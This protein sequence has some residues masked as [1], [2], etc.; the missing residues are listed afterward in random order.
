[1]HSKYRVVCMHWKQIALLVMF[2]VVGVNLLGRSYIPPLE[3][4]QEM[5]M[6]F[7]VRNPTKYDLE[8]LNVKVHI[9]D[10]GLTLFSNEFHLNDETHKLVR[11]SWIAPSRLGKGSYL[12]RISVGNDH[13][14]DINHVSLTAN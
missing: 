10:L 3:A 14:K 2:G 1:M 13:L 11:I 9:Y 4:G 7:T 8:D 6:F 5:E 12:A